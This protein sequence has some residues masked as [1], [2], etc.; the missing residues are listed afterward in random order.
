MPRKA[1]KKLE[2]AHIA[3][4]RPELIKQQNCKSQWEVS[5]E[6]KQKRKREK[7][8]TKVLTTPVA[9]NCCAWEVDINTA[10]LPPTLAIARKKLNSSHALARVCKKRDERRR[11]FFIFIFFCPDKFKQSL[12]IIRL[13]QLKEK[14]LLTLSPE[15]PLLTSARSSLLTR[16]IIINAS[17]ATTP[18]R[19]YLKGG[20]PAPETC[21]NTM[22]SAQLHHAEIRGL[23]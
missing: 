6:K 16:F 21:S 8:S 1:G 11:W 4:Q 14:K 15:S 13:T 7:Q 3:S 9:V 23:E 17:V 2:S 10:T 5:K 22:A 20:L 12:E 18:G 19:Q